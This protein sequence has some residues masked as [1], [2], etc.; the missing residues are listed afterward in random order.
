[1]KMKSTVCVVDRYPSSFEV[2]SQKE[3][4]ERNGQR[5]PKQQKI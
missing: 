2:S 1:M 3:D 5:I 4:K